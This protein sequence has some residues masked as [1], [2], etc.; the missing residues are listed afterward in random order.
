MFWVRVAIALALIALVLVTAGVRQRR[1]RL[2]TLDQPVLRRRVSSLPSGYRRMEQRL[3]PLGFRTVGDFDLCSRDGRRLYRMYLAW[4]D[5]ETTLAIRSREVFGF[6]TALAGGAAES[7]V[8]HTSVF[9]VERTHP[10]Y[11][12]QTVRGVKHGSESALLSIHREA[13]DLLGQ[14][15]W[16]E[17]DRR[18][19]PV[20]FARSVLVD[21]AVAH[22]EGTRRRGL[23]FGGAEHRTLRNGRAQVGAALRRDEP[24]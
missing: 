7:V 13:V 20:E 11:V 24:A 8:V 15:G 9:D 23:A 18:D 5:T 3:E 19:D 2:L 4:N 21:R 22:T 12:V 1:R 6:F 17:R 16:R 10:R 14:G